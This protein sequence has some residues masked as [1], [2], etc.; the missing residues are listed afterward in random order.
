MA[1][2][3]YRAMLV[4]VMEAWE[5]H[6]CYECE[7]VEV[8]P[9]VEAW[10]DGDPKLERQRDEERRLAEIRSLE[11]EVQ[12]LRAAATYAEEEAQAWRDVRVDPTEFI[13]QNVAGA[14]QKATNAAARLAHSEAKLKALTDTPSAQ[15][16]PQAVDPERAVADL[17][18]SIPHPAPQ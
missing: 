16:G 2:P 9:W 12:E 7:G 10:W 11:R 18:A 13:N 17:D 4:A 3:D 15:P 8:P 14:E 5:R 1:E 6:R